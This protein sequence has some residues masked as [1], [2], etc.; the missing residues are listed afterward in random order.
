VLTRLSRPVF[1]HLRSSLRECPHCHTGIMVV[2]DCI[3]RPKSLGYIMTR[4]QR[5]NRMK[6]NH[7]SDRDPDARAT[8]STGSSNQGPNGQIQAAVISRAPESYG[9]CLQPAGR[10]AAIVR[11]QNPRRQTTPI[12]LAASGAA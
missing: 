5:A 9:P 2:V 12:A 10:N 3:A 8:P 4:D 11:R 1:I 7:L 6:P